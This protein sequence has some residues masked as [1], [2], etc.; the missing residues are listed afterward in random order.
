MPLVPWDH[1]PPPRRSHPVAARGPPSLA[2]TGGA[3]RV[4]SLT[5]NRSSPWDERGGGGFLGVPPPLAQCPP[6]PTPR[7]RFWL[8]SPWG[9]TCEC[10]EGG[11]SP[12]G[13]TRAG[14]RLPRFAQCSLHV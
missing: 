2:Q 3:Q 9:P 14:L 5:A 10:T 1:G 6:H 4:C 8:F 7:K 12:R 11:V 13:A